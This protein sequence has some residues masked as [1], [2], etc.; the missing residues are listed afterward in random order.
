MSR[1][2]VFADPLP[3]ALPGTLADQPGRSSPRLRAAPA[4]RPLRQRGLTLVTLLLLGVLIALV[5]LVAM[6]VTPTVLEYFAIKK[7]VVKAAS[8]SPGG[9]PAEIRNAYE[10]SQIIE[11]FT[12][13]MP[14]DLVIVKDAQNRTTVNFAYEKKIPLFGPAFLL[15]EYKGDSK[16]H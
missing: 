10:R 2:R 13:V 15:I 16:S 11:D 6:R 4:P 7:A 12:S 8:S 9:V 3:I 14:K 5:A 1:P